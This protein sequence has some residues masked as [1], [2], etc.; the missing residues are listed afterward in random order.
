M[1]WT[2]VGADVEVVNEPSAFGRHSLHSRELAFA[3]SQMHAAGAK[4]T[5]GRRPRGRDAIATFR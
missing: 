3:G 4:A 2:L 5:R 1:Q